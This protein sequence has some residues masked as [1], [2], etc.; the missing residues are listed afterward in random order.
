MLAVTTYVKFQICHHEVGV[1]TEGSL[2]VGHPR[3]LVERGVCP[4]HV[5][6]LPTWGSRARSELRV[7]L[8]PSL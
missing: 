6:G 2:S 1:A 8:D 5:P 3:Y 7:W 4:S